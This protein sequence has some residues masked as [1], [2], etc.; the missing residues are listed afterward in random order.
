[1]VLPY[2]EDLVKGFNIGLTLRFQPV[3]HKLVQSSEAKT[4]TASFQSLTT[5]PVEF[6][7][8]FLGKA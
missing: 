4:G 5:N 8:C 2:G 7:T 3:T 1:M 6:G